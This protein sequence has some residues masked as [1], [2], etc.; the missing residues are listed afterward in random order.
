MYVSKTEKKLRDIISRV[1]TQLIVCKRV[2]VQVL[3][4]IPSV[5]LCVSVSVRLSGV[6]WKNG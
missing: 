2:L 3:S 6:L 1:A 5:G 4:P